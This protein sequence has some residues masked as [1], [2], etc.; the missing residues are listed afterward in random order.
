M[1]KVNE[2]RLLYI[3][4]YIPKIIRS[5]IPMKLEYLPINLLEY[6]PISK[7]TPV[8]E[9]LH[10]EKIKLDKVNL[11]VILLM[12]RPTVKESILTLK[13]SKTMLIKFRFMFISSFLK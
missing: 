4:W 11:L 6:L 1:G 3:M 12:A 5:I 10:I 9:K 13:A 8:N 2:N 7:P